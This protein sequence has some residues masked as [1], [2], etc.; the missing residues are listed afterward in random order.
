[1]EREGR[2]RS[3]P[4]A[5]PAALGL[6]AGAVVAWL[7][8]RSIF[9]VRTQ[10]FDP[11]I[12]VRSL[13]GF[14]HGDFDN[15]VFGSPGLAVH[16]QLALAALAPL[17]RLVSP[18]LLLVAA[19][20]L[21]LAAT[22][23][24]VARELGRIAGEHGRSAWLASLAGGAL[25]ILSPALVNPMLFDVRPDVWG[26]PLLVAGLL[27]AE[28]LGRFDARALAWLVAALLCRE[29]F[30]MVVAPAMLALPLP[31]GGERRVREKR[32]RIAVAVL[33]MGWWVAYVLVVRGWF[34][35]TASERQTGFLT[36]FMEGAGA[37]PL[38]ELLAYKAEILFAF[39]ATLGGLGLLAPRWLLTAAGG[40]L[41]VLVNN[42]LQ[43]LVLQFHYAMFAAPGL[44]VAG[45]AGWR[46][47]LARE[48]RPAWAP[49]LAGGLALAA[50]VLSSA[51]PGG[52]RFRNGFFLV[53]PDPDGRIAQSLA[54][55]AA[56]RALLDRIPAGAPAAVPG[57]Y[58]TTFA[59][60]ATLLVTEAFARGP[61]QAPMDVI[62]HVPADVRW[63]AVARDEWPSTGRRL[64]LEEGF[65]LAGIVPE[66]LALL[67]REPAPLP[68]EILDALR[69]LRCP[70]LQAEWPAEGLALCRLALGVDGRVAAVIRRTATP[71]DAPSATL[72]LG[73]QGAPPVPLSL[74]DG[75]VI[76]AQLPEGFVANAVSERPPGATS[77]VVALVT[78]EGRPMPARIPQAEGEPTLAAEVPVTWGKPAPR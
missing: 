45:V 54:R 56:A 65:R 47:W 21:A 68:P 6:G 22:V 57:A 30:A 29:D 52:R 76:P 28:R 25:A 49:A 62:E 12:Y 41:F 7:L 59:D 39:A 16:A 23:F 61:R 15:P 27:R 32:A 55:A 2:P 33:A 1:M 46:R 50:F 72:A 37:L 13:W 4:I 11:A 70:A 74:L 69:G 78:A 20:G 58:A 44:L 3:A 73:L 5:I 77:G 35:G 75:L 51:A 24:L 17:A 40:T 67:T 71:E 64:V 63:V 26:V 66:N 19:Q 53:G 14:A 38:G 31:S 43:P 34:G 10:S 8:H 42:R 18:A 9:V 60:R 36:K 48:R